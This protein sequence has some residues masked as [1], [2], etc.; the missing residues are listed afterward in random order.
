MSQ[1]ATRPCPFCGESIPTDVTRCPRCGEHLGARERS[2]PVGDT[3]LKA[4][5]VV[6]VAL[7]L[8]AALMVPCV[9]FGIAVQAALPPAQR[10]SPG[11][12]IAGLLFYVGIAAFF[13]VTGVGAW[14][15]R[16]WARPVMLSVAAPGL[17]MGIA[18]LAAMAMVYPTMMDMS[19]GAASASGGPTPPPAAFMSVVMVVVLVI[20][21]AI[22][23]GIPALLLALYWSSDLQAVCEQVDP[24]PRWTDGVP[25]P[26]LGTSL[27][28]GLF[29]AGS[30]CIPA[31]GVVPAFGALLT[32]WAAAAYAVVL[33]GACAGLAVAVFRRHPAG[34]LGALA[35][36]VV[37]GAS[38]LVSF[39][40]V[41]MIDLYRAMSMPPAQLQ[42]MESVDLTPMSRAA[43]WGGGAA[44]LAALAFLGYLRRFFVTAPS[45][46]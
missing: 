20:A 8:M 7:G 17:V 6:Q 39:S 25:I 28:L 12:A 33:A 13:L 40:R 34:W 15:H 2:G 9:G 45:G 22:Y 4:A 14:R 37:G 18:G 24:T 31:Y 21:A 26:I 29:A 38:H 46:T 32:G 19:L 3:R 23:V 10:Q 11:A 27:W 30:L 36:L 44:L 43:L 5:G 42:V 1:A 35:L 41:P 16:R